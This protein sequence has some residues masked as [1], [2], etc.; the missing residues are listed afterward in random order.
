MKIWLKCV[1]VHRSE[2]ECSLNI[3][4]PAG[5]QIVLTLEQFIRLV[6]LIK[7]IIREAA[8]KFLHKWSLLLIIDIQ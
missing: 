7:I 5:Q 3:T 6:L 4:I 8:K 2:Y 1:N